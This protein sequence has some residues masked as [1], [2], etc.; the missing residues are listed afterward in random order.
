MPIWYGVRTVRG[1]YVH[2]YLTFIGLEGVIYATQDSGGAGKMLR[3]S[4]L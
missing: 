1:A 4:R 2:V 3:L